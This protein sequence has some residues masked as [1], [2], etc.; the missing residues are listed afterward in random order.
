MLCQPQDPVLAHKPN[1]EELLY[2]SYTDHAKLLHLLE[3]VLRVDGLQVEAIDHVALHEVMVIPDGIDQDDAFFGAVL[4]EVGDG[5]GDGEA[6]VAF[7]DVVDQEE[8]GEEFVGFCE[9]G[10]ALAQAD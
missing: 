10:N 2:L 3:L 1:L 7:A 8:G 9:G 6:G 5:A 4:F